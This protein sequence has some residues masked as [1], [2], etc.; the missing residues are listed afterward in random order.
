M[1]SPAT[2]DEPTPLIMVWFAMVATGAAI[3]APLP[4]FGPQNCFANPNLQRSVRFL[5]PRGLAP[6]TNGRLWILI[7]AA[8]SAEDIRAAM[9]FEASAQSDGTA[10]FERL[11]V[12]GPFRISSR[13]VDAPTSEV[14]PPRGLWILSVRATCAVHDT[15]RVYDNGERPHAAGTSV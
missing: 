15:T 13:L 9:K 10:S 5:E 2:C 4:S 1:G 12:D 11:D 7:D 3:A 14:G 6:A 8:P